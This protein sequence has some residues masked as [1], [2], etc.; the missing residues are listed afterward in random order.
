VASVSRN[1]IIGLTGPIGAGKDEV[2]KILRR[3]RIPVIDADEIA[4]T[5]YVPQSPLWR[6]LVKAFGSRIL[7]RGGKINRKK[8]GAIVFSDKRE[9]RELNR[10][11]H[12]YL[13]KE[14]IRRLA[15]LVPR[16]SL[17]MINAAVLKEI[18]LL[19][20]VDEVWAI[21]A[22]KEVRLKRLLK[23]GLSKKDAEARLRSQMSRKDYIKIGT[24]VVENNGSKQ[25]LRKQ[26]LS[27][28]V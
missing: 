7:N 17:I 21:M 3:R 1:K 2:A 4:H 13:K 24:V 25:S 26:I 11:V 9:L 16:P 20:Y 10:L 28:L 19:D 8:L 5:L 6:K 23:S 22:S 18:G 12:P 27:L 14:I 15:S